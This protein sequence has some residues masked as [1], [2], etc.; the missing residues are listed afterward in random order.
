MSTG[1]TS[2]RATSAAKVAAPTITTSARSAL[3]QRQ[4]A[5]GAHATG[6]ECDDCK[7][8]KGLISRKGTGPAPATPSSLVAEALRSPGRP[9]DPDTR[10]FME[11]RFQRD[12][13]GVRVH[14]DARAADS[15]RALQARAW[16]WGSD[17]AFANGAY[18]PGTAAGRR[19]LAHELTH[20]VQQERAPAAPP[21][22][23]HDLDVSQPGDASEREADRV[24]DHVADSS[25]VVVRSPAAPDVIHRAWDDLSKGEKT[26]VIGGSILGGIQLNEKFYFETKAGLGDVPDWKFLVGWGK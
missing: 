5:C 11:S 2:A 14:T 9:L 22:A 4:C 23:D 12:F 8:K 26:A 20:V 10:G 15:A 16:A 18:A 7:K 19:L 21:A 3:L 13:S 1:P 24:A 6:G 17:V 25:P